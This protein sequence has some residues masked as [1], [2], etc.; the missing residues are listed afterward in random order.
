MM[1]MR[2]HRLALAAV[3]SAAAAVVNG[4]RAHAAERSHQLPSATHPR[5]R[6]RTLSVIPAF[7]LRRP[8]SAFQLRHSVTPSLSSYPSALLCAFDP[9]RGTVIVFHASPLIIFAVSTICPA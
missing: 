8:T 5:R 4:E 3:A 9:P 2:L 7:N 6:K 1:I